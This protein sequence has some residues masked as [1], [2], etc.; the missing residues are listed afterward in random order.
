M[1]TKAQATVSTFYDKFIRRTDCRI[2]CTHETNMEKEVKS[3]KT[4]LV[5]MAYLSTLL[6]YF[7]QLMFHLYEM[8]Y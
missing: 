1:H 7:H 6:Y 8:V 5:R 2:I 3:A 4:G